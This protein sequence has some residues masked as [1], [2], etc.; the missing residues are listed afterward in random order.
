MDWSHVIT[1]GKTEVSVTTG[2]R[3]K[4]QQCSNPNSQPGASPTRPLAQSRASTG[5]GK[6]Q[7]TGCANREPSTGERLQAA[8]HPHSCCQAHTCY[9]Q[10]QNPASTSAP[11]SAPSPQLPQGPWPSGQGRCGSQKQDLW[12]VEQAEEKTRPSISIKMLTC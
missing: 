2:H 11:V 8:A 5:D 7:G 6:M 10:I 1:P 9:C 4:L 3:P 12:A